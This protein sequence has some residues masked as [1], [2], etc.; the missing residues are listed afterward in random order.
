VN[1]Q[2]ASRI[3]KT[4]PASQL[5]LGLTEIGVASRERKPVSE[6]T[7]AKIRDAARKAP[8]APEPF[9]V[10]GVE[11]QV[12]GNEQLAANAF[13]AAK[14]R[15]ARSIPARYF[16]AQ[17]YFRTDDAERALREIAFLARSI[18]NGVV[19]L[20]PYVGSYAKDRRNWPQLKALFRANPA[21]GDATLTALATDPNNADI[22]LS[23]ADRRLM[24]PDSRWPAR[25]IDSLV[26]SGKYA[27]ARAVWAAIAGVPN[28]GRALVFDPEFRNGSAPPPFNWDL[29]S[30]TTGLAERGTGGGNLHVIFY[31]QEDG[32]LAGQL[33]VLPAGRYRLAMQVSGGPDPGKSLLWRVTCAGTNNQIAKMALEPAA[34]ASGWSFDVPAGCGAQKLQLLGSSTDFPQQTEVTIT[35]FRLERF[36]G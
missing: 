7:K 15:D 4:H 12:A 6:E 35:N 23:L 5:W 17:H 25:M 10:R 14:R 8:L 34:A 21:L 11:G 18:P 33:L 3:W 20:A 13:L 1:P 29:T 27:R 30:S 22:V 31:G 9:L 2:S 16:L 19:K 36:D 32:V 24:T 28:G 26:D